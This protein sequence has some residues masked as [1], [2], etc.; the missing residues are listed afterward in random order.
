MNDQAVTLVDVAKAAG[1]SPSTV[2]LVLNDRPHRISRRTSERVRRVAK[3]LKYQP[4][5]FARA[6]RT[7]R[8]QTVGIVA[9]LRN[10][11][12]VQVVRELGE[13]LRDGGNQLEIMDSG[14]GHAD[15]A[16][17]VEAMSRHRPKGVVLVGINGPDSEATSEL[18]RLH[19]AGLPAVL[20]GYRVPESRL[21]YL[22]T[23]Q[24][25]IGALAA[26]HMLDQGWSR[27][28]WIAGPQF[29]VL[30]QVAAMREHLVGF[31][32]ALADRRHELDERLVANVEPGGGSDVE[33]AITELLT[34]PRPN[35]VV[36]GGMELAARTL[37][38]ALEQG[39][40]VPRELG[41]LG[42][43]GTSEP[44]LMYPR[45]TT[46]GSPVA[47]RAAAIARMLRDMFDAP[48]SWDGQGIVMAPNLTVRASSFRSAGLRNDVH[49]F[50]TRTLG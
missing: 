17:A 8:Q 5:R 34:G 40:D 48:S 11:G 42:V 7:G 33:S 13:L 12:W 23:D 45:L 47:D 15:E 41:A 46:V 10:P 1:V 26:D 49:P 38:I 22:V 4:N 29:S 31:R 43:G 50:Q 21:P 35:A 3:R 32:R 14:R 20:V 6:L 19:I 16:R 28:G 2:S 9:P 18:E 27:I 39:L 25:R 37:R 44:E 24:E 30:G 36:I